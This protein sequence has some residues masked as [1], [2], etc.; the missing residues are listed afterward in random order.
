[1]STIVVDDHLLAD[2]LGQEVPPSLSRLLR[3]ND[4]ATTNLYYVRLCRAASHAR[5]GSI[6]GGW[7]DE[8]REQAVRALLDLSEDIVILPMRDLALKMAELA[9]AFSL[10][11]LGAEAVA[12]TAALG[13]RLCVWEGDVGPR[14]RDAC[15]SLRIKYQPIA[16]P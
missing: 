11:T 4:L 12:A 10:S 15:D 7:S 13:A 6:T 8:Y 14:T 3:Q 1:M 16:R 5:G 9:K 2:I